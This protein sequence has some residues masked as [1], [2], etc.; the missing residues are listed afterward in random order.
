MPIW[1]LNFPL[2]WDYD[3]VVMN[4]IH[5]YISKRNKNINGFKNVKSKT[6][7]QD[8]QNILLTLQISN[9]GALAF[10]TRVPI[11]LL[12]SWIFVCVY[13]LIFHY[14]N[15]KF[16]S[17]KLKIIFLPPPRLLSR[18]FTADSLMKIGLI[19]RLLQ[20][21]RLTFSWLKYHFLFVCFS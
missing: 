7:Y 20:K 13:C 5:K 21:L 4:N 19:L 14:N 16:C 1:L 18:H 10:K 9:Q 2:V 8:K 6:I 17:F 3:N 15:E 11:S 12:F